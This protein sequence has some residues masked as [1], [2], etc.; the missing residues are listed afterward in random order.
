MVGD[1]R[2]GDWFI[3]VPHP[4]WVGVFDFRV[5]F[6]GVDVASIQFRLEPR[7][8]VMATLNVLSASGR[9]IIEPGLAVSSSMPPVEVTISDDG[10]TIDGDV[11]ADDA[12]ASAWIYLERE[13]SPARNEQT[14]QKGHFRFEAVAPGD[15]QIYEKAGVR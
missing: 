2:D 10:G 3:V 7:I 6:P 9:D 4:A 5:V 8:N 11:A 14:D 1:E 13:G 15:Y 12:P